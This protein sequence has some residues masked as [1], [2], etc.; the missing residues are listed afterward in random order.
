MR[1]TNAPVRGIQSVMDSFHG[2]RV[3]SSGSS[4]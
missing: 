3:W 4:S 1:L 2:R